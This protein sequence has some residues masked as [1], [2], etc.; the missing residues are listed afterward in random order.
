MTDDLNLITAMATSASMQTA[1]PALMRKSSS[2]ESILI[3]VPQTGKQ[4][5]TVFSDDEFDEDGV[6]LTAS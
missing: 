2:L 6:P 5:L 4:K 3:D 1:Q